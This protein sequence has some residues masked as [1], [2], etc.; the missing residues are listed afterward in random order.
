[1]AII[2]TGVLLL[3]L[4]G[5]N[6][7]STPLPP[8]PAAAFQVGDTLPG[9]LHVLPRGSRADVVTKGR[10]LN[11]QWTVEICRLLDTGHADDAKFQVGVDTVFSIAMTDNSGGTHNG[12]RRIDL[13]WQGVP[14][15]QNVV[16]GDLATLG[17]SA[18]VIDGDASDQAW[19]AAPTS[20]L[21]LYPMAGDN[22]I[23][24]ATVQAAWLDRFIYFRVT[25]SDSTENTRRKRWSYDGNTWTRGGENE[26]RLYF[27]FEIVGAM[28]TSSPGFMSGTTTPFSQGGCTISCHGDGMMR[29]DPGRV[30]TWHW[31]ATRTDP[32]GFLDDK[33]MVAADPGQNGRKSDEGTAAYIENKDTAGT[34][35]GWRSARGY[36]A[37]P[38]FLF[39]LPEDDDFT[40]A[41]TDNAG[42]AAGNILPGYVQ[43]VPGNSRADVWTKGKFDNGT[44][45]VEFCRALD[46]GSTWETGGP[47]RLREDISWRDGDTIPGYVT[48]PPIGS[49]GDVKAMGRWVGGFWTVEICR[50]LDTGNPDDV[51]FTTNDTMVMS[52]GIADNSG[53][54]HNGAPSVNLEWAGLAGPMTVVAEL[55]GSTSPPSIDGAG[56]DA[57]WAAAQ[58]SSVPL[59]AQSGANRIY[60][61]D[62]QA[63]RDG[64]RIYF[65]FVWEDPTHNEFREQWTFANGVWSQNSQNED[66]LYVMFDIDGARG[67]GTPG[68]DDGVGTTPFTGGAPGGCTVLCHGDGRMRTGSGTIDTWH[69]KATRNNGSGWLDDKNADSSDRHK[70][71][72]AGLGTRNRN[73]AKTM[74]N[75]QAFADPGARVLHLPFQGKQSADDAAFVLGYTLPFALGLT[76]NAGGSH[77]GAPLLHLKWSGTSIPTELVALDLAPTGAPPPVID[78]VGTDGAWGLASP[79]DVVCTPQSGGGFGITAAELRAVHDRDHLY[80]RVIWTDPSGTRDQLKKRRVFAVSSVAHGGGDIFLTTGDLDYQKILAWITQ[81]APNN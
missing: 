13:T 42:F 60:G 46:S 44:W 19:S 21:A 32:A 15:W 63:V 36:N 38:D 39:M 3:P 22:G 58:T 40:V 37:N 33:F 77:D 67:T 61:V 4:A 17:A 50:D 47:V 76:D 79:A 1:M 51:V 26:D 35:P 59:T 53:G 57:A 62:V 45:T 75:Y 80:V 25:W 20:S 10:Y 34:G 56:S 29:L 28:G 74:P 48:V 23:S 6:N 49:F 12:A 31:K 71:D 30:D 18:P 52:L 72:G 16:V 69:W 2:V 78:G 73:A 27:M 43:R 41:R 9:Y 24:G 7:S 11:G 81:G 64:S 68:A 14:Q 8:P 66:R 5:C 55:L 54:T 65:K 70:D